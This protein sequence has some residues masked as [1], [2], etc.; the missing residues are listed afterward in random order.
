MIA[1]FGGRELQTAVKNVPFNSYVIFNS[2][3]GRNMQSVRL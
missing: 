2:L 3:Q 1:L